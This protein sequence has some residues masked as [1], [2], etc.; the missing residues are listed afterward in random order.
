MKVHRR[1]CL[2]LNSDSDLLVTPAAMQP[3]SHAE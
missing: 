3:R 2:C 1:I